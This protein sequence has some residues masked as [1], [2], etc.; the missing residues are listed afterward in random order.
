MP[1]LRWPWGRRAKPK[2]EPR[3]P[4]KDLATLIEELRIAQTFAGFAAGRSGVPEDLQKV[5]KKAEQE[6]IAALEDP[7]QKE[8]FGILAKYNFNLLEFLREDWEGVLRRS[9]GEISDFLGK[10]YLEGSEWKEY[11]FTGEEL[12]LWLL[13]RVKGA[14]PAERLVPIFA[15]LEEDR[16]CGFDLSFRARQCLA[17]K[18]LVVFFGTFAKQF[19][20]FLEIV[21][22]V[23]GGEEFIRE[24]LMARV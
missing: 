8:I 13:Q 18:L 19:K 4:K 20:V 9:F 24:K 6:A 12:Y 14:E 11:P 17:D 1:L 2:L 15:S 3:K 21:R 10:P 5:L 23:A 16:I 22:D 7:L